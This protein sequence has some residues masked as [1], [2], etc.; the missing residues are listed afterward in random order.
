MAPRPQEIK[1]WQ[2]NC[3]GYKIKRGSLQFHIQQLSEKP[4]VI[5]LQEASHPI[6]IAGYTP[7]IPPNTDPKKTISVTATSVQRNI[8]AIQHEIEDTRIQHTQVEIPP[9][10][11]GGGK[12]CILN[13]YSSPKDKTKATSDIIRKA[14]KLAGKSQLVVVGDFNAHHSVWGYRK[15]HIKGTALW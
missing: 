1:I 10:K 14:V 4:D 15:A 6:N 3:R 12:V 5:V 9:R 8:V 11:K 2:W 13:V 7:F